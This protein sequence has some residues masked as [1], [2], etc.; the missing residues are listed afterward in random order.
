[1]FGF[2]LTDVD[3]SLRPSNEVLTLE[4]QDQDQQLIAT[5]E[6][7]EGPGYGQQIVAGVMQGWLVSSV[8]AV[9]L[10]ALVGWWV[11][12]QVSA[13]VLAL[14]TATR[15]MASGDLGVRASV[16]NQDEIGELAGSFNEMVE[17]VESTVETLRR[18][19]SDA[20]HE[21][22]TPLTALRANV[23]LALQSDGPAARAS[24]ERA[25][26]QGSRLESLTRDLLDLSRLEAQA[27]GEPVEPVD[28]V[29]L[30]REQAEPFA[31]QAEQ[32]GVTFELDL[33]AEPLIVMGERSRL[34]RALR[35]LLENAVKFTPSS[36]RIICGAAREGEEAHLWVQDSGIGIPEEDRSML[37][38]RFHR[39]RNASG[40]PGSGLGLAILRAIAER[41]HGRIEVEHLAPGTRFRLIFPGQ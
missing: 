39:G 21:L 26:E 24:L 19:A 29:A 13:P 10:A 18:F 28:L 17:R 22:N 8:V 41:H 23:E 1:M 32:A 7:S 12:R 14:T 31:S 3:Q 25:L 4:I 34:G 16:R 27:N 11:S 9:L 2:Q 30:A 37:F 6:L 5:L 38:Q 33:P 36:G 40:Y 35:N 15:R 20:A